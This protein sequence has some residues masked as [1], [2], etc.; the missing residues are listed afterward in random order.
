MTSLA[1]P[2]RETSP[3]EIVSIGKEL[4][5]GRIQ[6][7]NSFW[8]AQQI[9]DLGGT[10]QR[11]SVVDDDQPTIVKTLRDAVEHGAKTIVTTGGLGPTPDDLTV[12]SVAELLGVDTHVDRNVVTDYLRRRAI[13]EDEISPALRAM[14]TVPI[15]T[16][17][18]PSP[19]GWAP[20]IRADVNGCSIFLLPG[21]PQE[22][23]A[24]FA[25]YLADYFGGAQ[26]ALRAITHRVYVD[27][28]E[29]EVSP[30]LQQ[31][32]D[33]VPG[34][35]CKGYIALGNQRFL[36]IDVVARGEHDEAAQLALAQALDLLERLIAETGRDFQR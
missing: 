34:T 8:L 33:A 19:A 27:M 15:G 3:I 22:V 32:M 17:V 35:Y 25:R 36:P 13:S 2:S 4:L 31:V 29:S 1:D 21:P 26:H 6:D 30:L 23:Q 18:F 20:L 11:I 24:I 16:D 7:T 28:W 12:A 9:T 5:I 10:M 14:A